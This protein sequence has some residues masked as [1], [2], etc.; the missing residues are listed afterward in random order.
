MH[1][2]YY[3]RSNC[4]PGTSQNRSNILWFEPLENATSCNLIVHSL[5]WLIA[6]CFLVTHVLF[7]YFFYFFLRTLCKY[8]QH[9]VKSIPCV[10]T[11]PLLPMWFFSSEGVQWWPIYEKLL[12]LEKSILREFYNL[13]LGFIFCLIQAGMEGDSFISANTSSAQLLCPNTSVSC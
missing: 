8:F 3:P 5:T 13:C 9:K 2:I 7:F 11:Q 10:E 6:A 1:V 12:V 4:K